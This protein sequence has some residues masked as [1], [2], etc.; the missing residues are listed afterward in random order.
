MC[1]GEPCDNIEGFVT[2]DVS[3]DGSYLDIFIQMT[4]LPHSSAVPQFMEAGIYGPAK[5][6]AA[7]PSGTPPRVVITKP[8]LTLQD[9]RF[10]GLFKRKAA[11]MASLLKMMRE[12]SLYVSV[13][14]DRVPEG[15]IRGQLHV[16]TCLETELRSPM[17][18]FPAGYGATGAAYGFANVMIDKA[19]EKAAVL[20][21]FPQDARRALSSKP[22]F[23]DGQVRSSHVT[24]LGLPCPL[25]ASSG[26]CAGG[27]HVT[28]M[29]GR[30]L[31]VVQPNAWESCRT[32]SFD[33]FKSDAK[34]S[35]CNFDEKHSYPSEVNMANSG[36]LY[37]HVE[38]ALEA[39]DAAAFVNSTVAVKTAKS[40]EMGYA[41][42]VQGRLEHAIPC[43]KLLT[44][45]DDLY[46]MAAGHRSDWITVWSLNH[47]HAHVARSTNPDVRPTLEPRYLAP[48]HRTKSR[49]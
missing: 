30:P 20:V 35:K 14:S 1:A 4:A 34:I 45:H 29:D 49:H 40:E 18:S 24:T 32:G 46:T 5:S 37:Y 23:S 10:S 39:G 6:H 19:Q 3:P 44:Q 36:V 25:G 48:K 8:S 42:E 33:G 17:P 15:E 47:G 21:Q 26:Q 9:S 22:F 43:R 11:D 2:V 7:M 28:S 12:E 16:P 41:S 38:M 27:V 31:A 13:P